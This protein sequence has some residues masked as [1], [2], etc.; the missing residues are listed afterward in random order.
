MH[1]GGIN[2][3]ALQL[4]ITKRALSSN[5]TA[6]NNRGNLSGM[7]RKEFDMI[8]SSKLKVLS[9]Q[10]LARKHAAS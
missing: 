4:V 10:D 1:Q 6:A 3:N 9:L 2:L 5:P 7:H 8:I